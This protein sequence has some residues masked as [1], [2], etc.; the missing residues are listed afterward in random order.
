MKTLNARQYRCPLNSPLAPRR[1][2]YNYHIL[3][4]SFFSVPDTSKKAFSRIVMVWASIS[5]A[6]FTGCDNLS[7]LFSSLREWFSIA[8]FATLGWCSTCHMEE[9]ETYV[10]TNVTLVNKS[11]RKP[12]A[13]TVDTA[14]TAGVGSTSAF[15]IRLNTCISYNSELYIWVRKLETSLSTPETFT[16][17]PAVISTGCTLWQA[18][19]AKETAWINT[20][21][22]I[23]KLYWPGWNAPQ[24]HIKWKGQGTEKCVC[25]LLCT[26][27]IKVKTSINISWKTKAEHSVT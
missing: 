4:L 11:F 10:F 14:G 22:R 25:C 8:Y 17:A 5:W 23:R 7:L 20:L 1:H 27:G 12:T 15:T 3:L 9:L 21:K 2:V 19:P 13:N 6:L 18:L 24:R 26:K 16:Q